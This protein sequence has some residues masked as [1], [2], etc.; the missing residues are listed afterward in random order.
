MTCKYWLN[1]R[2]CYRMDTCPFQHPTGPDFEKA[3]EIWVQ[4]RLEI[5]K[6][7]TADPDDPHKD[8][9]PHALRALIFAQWIHT[10]LVPKLVRSS[11]SQGKK[12]TT[13]LDVAGGKGDVSMFLCHAF[14]L[15]STVVE[16]N[17][18]KQ[19]NYWFTR[20]RRLMEKHING[21][22][23]GDDDDD[24]NATTKRSQPW[25]YPDIKPVFMP[26]LLDDA[27]IHTHH[28]LILRTTL[29]IGLHADQATEPIVD[30]AIQLGIPFAVV[31]CCVF[32]RENL[33]RQLSTGAP[34]LTTKDLIQYL[35]EK[36]T[37]AYGGKIETAYLD[38]EGKNE[39][40][41][42]IPDNQSSHLESTSVD[43]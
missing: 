34:V 38:F 1:Q 21:N 30:T 18:R 6:I 31:P 12:K 40:V 36:D 9:K 13:V 28:D 8:K 15:P 35:C 27:F 11:S 14:G 2:K 3:R 17:V 19:P 26:T 4:E 20:L 22:G 39:V 43:S 24:D 33:H 10:S 5:R 16:P 42:W 25:P 37:G 32:G 41:Y 29:M 7:I 23:N